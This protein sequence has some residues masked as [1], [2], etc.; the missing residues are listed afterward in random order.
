[1]QV[2]FAVKPWKPPFGQPILASTCQSASL[3][4][5]RLSTRQLVK[6]FNL[7]LSICFF[8]AGSVWNVFS[9]V[10][11]YLVSG[12]WRHLA[13]GI[14]SGLYMR[15]APGAAALIKQL[16]RPAWWKGNYIGESKAVSFL[17][18]PR[19]SSSTSLVA[20]HWQALLWQP[21]KLVK[22]QMT[23]ELFEFPV[24]R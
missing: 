15:N 9:D 11:W 2:H 7:C 10:W 5:Q 4:K 8:L 21:V 23:S 13:A 12:R 22:P 20:L 6:L 24:Q 14:G 3:Q 18:V 17:T 19:C 16:Y 1:V